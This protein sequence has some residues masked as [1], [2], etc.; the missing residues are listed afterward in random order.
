MAKI[1]YISQDIYKIK[2]NY[3][4]KTRLYFNINNSNINTMKL[5]IDELNEINEKLDTKMKNPNRQFDINSN[6]ITNIIDTINNYI[7]KIQQLKIKENFVDNNPDLY[8]NEIII[9]IKEKNNELKDSSKKS[10][11]LIDKLEKIKEQEN[12]YKIV[13]ENKNAYYKYLNQM[14][15]YYRVETNKDT[16]IENENYYLIKLNKLLINL[17][18]SIE[19]LNIVLYDK[20]KSLN[21]WKLKY[22]KSDITT[23]S[24]THDSAELNKLQIDLINLQKEIDEKNKT[25]DNTNLLKKAENKL[26]QVQK[27]YFDL[28]NKNTNY[29]ENFIDYKSAE[30]HNNQFLSIIPQTDDNYKIRVN[31]KCLSV[32]DVNDYRLDNCNINTQS[33]LFKPVKINSKSDALMNNKDIILENGE[34]TNYPYYQ[35]KSAISFDCIGVDNEGISVSTCNSNNIKH[36]FNIII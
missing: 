23:I 24:Y 16:N 29:L 31:D 19:E 9:Y 4:D 35:L 14:I 2:Q 30:S 11:D 5:K 6:K 27:I 7:Y 18:K 15:D 17:D 3:Q 26:K 20:Q 10:N 34:K 36:N 25:I 13:Y 1:N 28:K 33:Q 22:D 32:Y 8:P 12:N 21:K